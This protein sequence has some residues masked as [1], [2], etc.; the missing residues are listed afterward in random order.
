MTAIRD[1]LIKA[2]VIK[3]ATPTKASNELPKQSK[4]EEAK[5][6]PKKKGRIK[7]KPLTLE[8]KLAAHREAREKSHANKPRGNICILCG[9]TVPHGQLLD[10]K[11]LVHGERQ[12]TPS[13]IREV[14]PPDAVFVRGGSP[15]LRK[16]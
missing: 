1:A 13:P 11:A 15:G 7:P 8:Q 5:R 16:R 14:H 3:P 12:I 2:G 10:H 4:P 9:A 6:K